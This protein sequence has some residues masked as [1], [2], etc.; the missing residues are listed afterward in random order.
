MIDAADELVL[1]E[2]LLNSMKVKKCDEKMKRYC[3]HL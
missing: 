3:L 2:A 1:Y